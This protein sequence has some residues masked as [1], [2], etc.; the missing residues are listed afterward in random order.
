MEY[1]IENEYLKVTVTTWA[2]LPEEL[3]CITRSEITVR[4]WPYTPRDAPQRKYR[5]GWGS[6]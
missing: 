2:L 5:R 6:V 4:Y 3:G 1:S